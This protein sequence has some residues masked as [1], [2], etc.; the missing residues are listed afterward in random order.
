MELYLNGEL[1]NEE[2]YRTDTLEELMDVIQNELV[3][4]YLS[5]IIVDGEQ[6]SFHQLIEEGLELDAI[7]SLHLTTSS[8]DGL[9]QET[10]EQAGDYLPRL[11]QGLVDLGVFFQEQELDKAQRH[12]SICLEGLQWYLNALSK[13]LILL[14]DQG[15]SGQ[16][17]KFIKELNQVLKNVNQALNDGDM[18]EAAQLL[19]GEAASYV[20]FFIDFNETVTR[21]LKVE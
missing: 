13:V 7:E 12:L 21:H 18:E 2:Q 5:E 6:R 3:D 4:E 1:R 20:Q 17:Q 8:I 11:K 15:L 9:I 14:D 19:S 16:G 10:L